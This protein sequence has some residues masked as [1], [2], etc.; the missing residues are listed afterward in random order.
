MQQK[1]IPQNSQNRR[2]LWETLME[3][4]PPSYSDLKMTSRRPDQPPHENLTVRGDSK[5]PTYQLNNLRGDQTL[6]EFE[7]YQPCYTIT[8]CDKPYVTLRKGGRLGNKMCQYT[9][10]YLLRHLFGIRV[11]HC[12]LP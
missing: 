9:S 3:G 11:S 2:L 10:L 4:N 6:V 5:S 8:D 12:S 1:C 7:S